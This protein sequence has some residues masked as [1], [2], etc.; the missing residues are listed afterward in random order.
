MS[1]NRG[2]SCTTTIYLLRHGDSRQDDVKRY[3]GQADLPLN[4]EGRIQAT[5]WRNKL[6]AIPLHR[7]FCSD[8]SRSYETACIIAEGR[9]EPV[10]P[11]PRLREIDLGGW[12]GL[13]FEEVRR[14]YPSEYRNRGADLISYRT[15]GGE[16]FADVAARVVPLFEQIV[17]GVTGN[18]LV[19]GHSGVNRVILCHILGMPMANMFRIRQDYGC[20]TVIDCSKDGMCVR[21]MNMCNL[22]LQCDIFTEPS[23]NL[24]RSSADSVYEEM[25]A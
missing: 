20:L 11:L 6:A 7:I 3:V 5:G 1:D 8:L 21:G 24:L 10:Q 2:N 15:P 13:T 16:C 23:L 14:F 17:H 25:G 9:S 18:V 19:V 22:A 12:E 4:A